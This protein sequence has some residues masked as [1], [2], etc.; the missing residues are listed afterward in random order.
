[1]KSG[2]DTVQLLASSCDGVP[3]TVQSHQEDK[4][5]SETHKITFAG[6]IEVVHDRNLET[7]TFRPMVSDGNQPGYFMA[8]L[9]SYVTTVSPCGSVSG[10]NSFQ[11]PYGIGPDWRNLDLVSATP[12]LNEQIPS[13]Q[14]MSF[15]PI[16]TFWVFPPTPPVWRH[17][18]HLQLVALDRSTPL[19]H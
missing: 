11:W 15:A 12:L 19:P 2:R 1:M 4:T 10:G 6:A 18:L 17:T 13:D 9:A 16:D 5:F 7:Y 14:S 3:A 8:N